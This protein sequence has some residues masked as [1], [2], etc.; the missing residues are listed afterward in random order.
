MDDGLC[1][2]VKYGN[3]DNI[4]FIIQDTEIAGWPGCQFFGYIYSFTFGMQVPRHECRRSKG[5][6]QKSILSFHHVGSRAKA[7]GWAASVFTCWAIPLALKLWFL[8]EGLSVKQP[9]RP[10]PVHKESNCVSDSWFRCQGS[11]SIFLGKWG[12]LLGFSISSGMKISPCSTSYWPP[13]LWQ[14]NR[15]ILFNSKGGNHSEL[16]CWIWVQFF[17]SIR[18]YKLTVSM[19]CSRKPS[20]LRLPCKRV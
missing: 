12:L 17:C 2:S 8:S 20:K 11:S 15:P 5:N 16:I 18:R 9:A 4:G 14:L 10:L 3:S 1:S 13:H 19:I 7:S 6:L